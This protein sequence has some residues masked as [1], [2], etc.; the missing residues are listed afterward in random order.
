MSLP[1]PQPRKHLH[2]RQVSFDGYLREDGL[3]DIEAQMIDT[4]AY[5]MVSPEKGPMAPG[6]PVH[7]M[8]IRATVDDTLTIREISTAMA[9]K[10]FS[11]CLKAQDP[12]QK[13]VGVRMGPGWRHAIEKAV[14]GTRGCTHMRELLFNL[15]TAA[16]Q[17]IPVY[18]TH[19]E[20][21]SIMPPGVD[22]Q[23]PRHLGQCLAWDFNGVVVQRH[24]PMYV[25]WQP[26]V[27]AK[28]VGSE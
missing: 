10:P 5:P 2:H 22:G 4:K 25:G 8:Y 24:Y 9:S 18:Q 17:T 13:M 16:Y 21:L 28:P 23:P 26:L 12:M 11:E 6:M 27:K 19:R 15:A 14:G 3:W 7:D 20:D 1:P